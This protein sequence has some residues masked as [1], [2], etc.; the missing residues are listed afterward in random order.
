[1]ITRIRNSF[2]AGLALIVP[3][4]VT[5]FFLKFLLN[6][7]NTVIVEPT[8]KLLHLHFVFPYSKYIMKTA[9]FLGVL[10]LITLVGVAA[11]M[12]FVKQF[13][14]LGEKILYKLPLVNKV[15]QA[16]KEISNA[17]LG[18]RRGIF[19]RVVLIEYPRKGT[20]T[21]GFV[22]SKGKGELQRKTSRQVLNIFVP[23]S[24]NPTSG[25]FLMVPEEDTVPLSIS[26]EEGMKIVVSGG[27]VSPP[28]RL[29]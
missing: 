29:K 20:Y 27:A 16:T 24:P 18:E 11:R 4:V 2:F 14:G 22:T 3:L 9:V 1:M 6:F 28:E 8:I 12:F 19:L 15:Y 25:Y 23:T 17:F 10:G 26:V 7:S 5:F 13:F 21:I